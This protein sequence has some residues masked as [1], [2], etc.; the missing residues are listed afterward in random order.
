MSKENLNCFLCVTSQNN[1]YRIK[2]DKCLRFF[3][4]LIIQH[5]IVEDPTMD[6]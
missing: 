4:K 5:F 3:F 2:S 6:Q 1:N